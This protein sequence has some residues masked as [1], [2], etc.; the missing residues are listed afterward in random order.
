MG[1]REN[2]YQIAENDILCMQF[3]EF[4]L[5]FHNSCEIW[6]SFSR[7]LMENICKAQLQILQS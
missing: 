3:S 1:A 5:C 7:T 2:K 4:Y 6:Q